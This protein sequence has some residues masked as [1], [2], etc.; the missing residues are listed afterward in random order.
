[1]CGVLPQRRKNSRPFPRTKSSA[2]CKPAKTLFQ[3]PCLRQIG[4]VKNASA[5]SYKATSF[6]KVELA[7]IIFPSSALACMVGPKL[8]Q[9]WH[10]CWKK[11]PPALMFKDALLAHCFFSSVN[12]DNLKLVNLFDRFRDLYSPWVSSK[13]NPNLFQGLSLETF[14]GPSHQHA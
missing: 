11:L 9:G 7:E 10:H 3:E 2:T 13:M 1:M 6:S 8:F 14:S 12:M 5:S 4:R